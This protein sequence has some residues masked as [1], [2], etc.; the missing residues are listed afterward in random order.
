MGRHLTFSSPS[1]PGSPPELLAGND[2]TVGGTYGGIEPPML[3]LGEGLDV[4]LRG[5][6][7]DMRDAGE[8][9]PLCASSFSASAF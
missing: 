3:F 9:N 4:P 7:R 8:L 5:A 2:G 1:V 6:A